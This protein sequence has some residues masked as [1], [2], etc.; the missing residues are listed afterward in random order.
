MLNLCRGWGQFRFAPA[1]A[2]CL[3]TLAQ[4]LS[5][6]RT[7]VTSKSN[8]RHG[9]RLNG[10]ARRTWLTHAAASDMQIWCHGPLID[11]RRRHNPSLADTWTWYYRSLADTRR[12]YRTSFSGTRSQYCRM[13]GDTRSRRRRLLVYRTAAFPAAITVGMRVFPGSEHPFHRPALNRSAASRF[14]HTHILV[15]IRTAWS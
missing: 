3:A 12:W 7:P 2:A 11:C 13:L 15:G 5:L 14:A 4:R 8:R 9:G 10:R 1:L 6:S